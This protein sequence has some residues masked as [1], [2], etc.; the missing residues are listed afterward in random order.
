MCVATIGVFASAP[1]A[2]LSGWRT[3]TV[4]EVAVDARDGD[5][6]DVA[7]P[8][9]QPTR[10]A[11]PDHRAFPNGRC[12]GD[13]AKLFVFCCRWKNATDV[14]NAAFNVRLLIRE[15][16]RAPPMN[17]WMWTDDGDG[18]FFDYYVTVK[19]VTV[20]ITLDLSPSN[21]NINDDL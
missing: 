8:T 13:Y 5:G 1:A 6:N 2:E 11:P 17:P 15:E 16:G 14:Q 18:E 7:T 9:D 12:A 20:T 19:D 21:V 4:E 10:S 3:R